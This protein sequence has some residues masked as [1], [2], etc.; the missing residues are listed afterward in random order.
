MELV[1]GRTLREALGAG[2]LPTRQVYALLDQLLAAAGHAHEHGVIDRD[3]KPDNVFIAR[4]GTVKL[5][6]F[7]IAKL[8]QSGPDLTRAGTLIGTP[9]YMAPEQI[10]AASRSTRAATSSVSGSSPTSVWPARTR[11]AARL[12]PT[13]R[14]SS[15]AS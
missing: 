6:D 13:M 2:A 8:A 9:A 10:L 3:L 14:R 7:G 4:D 1:E 15:T 5:A 11:S 12:R